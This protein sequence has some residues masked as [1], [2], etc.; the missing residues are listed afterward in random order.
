MPKDLTRHTETGRV[1]TK[2]ERILTCE[3]RKLRG[4]ETRA[5]KGRVA[6]RR[7]QGR[8]RGATRARSGDRTICHDRVV[9][10]VELSTRHPPPPPPPPLR[11]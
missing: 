9:E 2:R 4:L 3:G 8:M 1:L 10:T 6:H 7:P 5:D 11:H